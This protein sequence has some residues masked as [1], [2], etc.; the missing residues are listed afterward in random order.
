MS[1]LSDIGRYLLDV[2]V[3][4]IESFQRV[5]PVERCSLRQLGDGI[6]CR[7]ELDLWRRE[8]ERE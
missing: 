6:V 5:H 4:E 1:Q 2:I 7:V 3:R 8:R